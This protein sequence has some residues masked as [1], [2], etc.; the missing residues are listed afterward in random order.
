MAVLLDRLARDAS[1]PDT[2]RVSGHRF[3][4]ALKL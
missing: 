2:E 4:N 1:L 3:E